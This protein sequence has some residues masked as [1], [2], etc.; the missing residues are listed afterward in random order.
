MSDDYVRAVEQA[1]YALELAKR[2]QTE[3][4]DHSREASFHTQ[5]M[6]DALHR[7]DHYIQQA[8]A[9]EAVAAKIKAEEEANARENVAH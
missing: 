3:A 8:R 9:F 6:R 5:Q 4:E 2:S 1:R 7:R